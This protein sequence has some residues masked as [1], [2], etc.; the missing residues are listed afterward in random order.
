MMRE[1]EEEGELPSGALAGWLQEQGSPEAEPPRKRKR[2][3]AAGGGGPEPCRAHLRGVCKSATCGFSHAAQPCRLWAVGSCM[4]GANCRDV[5]A[6]PPGRSAP[7]PAFTA[8]QA[9][10]FRALVG[11]PDAAQRVGELREL[12][13]LVV[14]PLR[15]GAPAAVAS[16]EEREREAARGVCA[17]NC[18]CLVC[19]GGRVEEEGQG[20]EAL[21]REAVQA[22]LATA[23]RVAAGKS[24][25]MWAGVLGAIRARR[26]GLP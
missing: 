8:E 22:R 13:G 17:R 14:L 4:S 10:R 25:A 1:P 3:A 7:P 20:G 5:H 9:S 6:G 2:G 16:A 23:S 18:G 21:G 11:A 26:T 12:V 19:R 15:P 24:Q